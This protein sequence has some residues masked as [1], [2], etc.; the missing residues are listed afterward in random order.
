MKKEEIQAIRGRVSALSPLVHAITNPISI[1]QCANCILATG[2]RAIMAEH[3][4]EVSEITAGADALVLNLGNLTSVRMR[5]M[6]RSAQTAV[7]HNIPIVLDAVGVG[8]S[9]L[10]R[11]FAQ[12]LLKKYN[13]CVV[14]GNYS[15][16][17]SLCTAEYRCTGVDAENAPDVTSISRQ[18][19]LLAKRHKA[20]VLASG[21]TDII[22]DGNRV[23]YIKNGVPMLSRVTG[24]GCMLGVLV[25]CYMAVQRD[26]TAVA[27]A[28]AVLGI[29]GELAGEEGSGSFMVRLLNHLST[30]NGTTLAGYLKW[31]E[32]DEIL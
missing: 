5:S 11:Q 25:G 23:V 4:S 9:G 18:A 29:C 14:K 13:I 20:I 3:P 21:K 16:I 30:L 8:C 19:V 24:T 6:K 12:R 15:E 31:E 26:I 7:L 27:A 22:T 28:C 2:A 10:R 32:N 17:C 1:N